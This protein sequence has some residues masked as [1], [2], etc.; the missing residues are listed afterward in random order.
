M[1]TIVAFH[2]PNA[3]YR[4]VGASDGGMWLMIAVGSD[5]Q[6]GREALHSILVHHVGHIKSTQ[7]LFPCTSC[8]N[9]VLL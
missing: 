5:D 4:V 2:L 7:M 6:L 1:P 3:F 8:A 9:S